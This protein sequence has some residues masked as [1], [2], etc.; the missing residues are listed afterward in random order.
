MP[1]PRSGRSVGCY[2]PRVNLGAL[3][4]RSGTLAKALGALS[5]LVALAA[6]AL[7]S[8]VGASP[9]EDYHL[10]SVW[11]GHGTRDGACEEGP[12]SAS[13]RVPAA[14]Y[15]IACFAFE[16]QTSASCQ[17]DVLAS[18]ERLMVI[19]RG[20]FTGDYPPVFYFFMSLFA[21]RDIVVSAAVMRLVNAVLFVA[22]IAATYIASPPRLRRP[23]LGGIAVTVVPLSMF[24]VPSINPSSWA[25]LSAATLLVSVLGY[26]TTDE[27]GRR[28]VLGG[29]AALSLLFGAGARADAAV[30]AVVAIAAALV[31]T[32][33]SGTRHIRRA[34]YPVVLAIIAGVSFLSSGQS[35]AI[36]GGQSQGLTLARV[37]HLL[38]DVPSLWAGCLGTWG[39]GWVDTPM[40]A[41]VWVATIGIFAGVVFVAI[42]GMD[43][44]RALALGLVGAAVWLVPAYLQ[45]L[46]GVPVGFD[47]QP[48]YILPLLIVLAVT[49]LVRLDGAVFRLTQGQRWIFVLALSVANAVALHTNLRRYI[50]GIDVESL[51]LNAHKEWWWGLPISPLGVWALGALA[52]A[53]GL[54]ILSRELT[55]VVAVPAEVAAA[56]EEPEP[57]TDDAP[58]AEP[59]GVV[60]A[61]AETATPHEEPE[62]ET[63]AAG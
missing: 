19:A 15:N 28:L 22:M 59:A 24:I 56:D 4:G 34:I 2:A 57:E 29:L 27:R 31:L 12:D 58:S 50:T 37:V 13:R 35:G 39:L 51:N 25:V 33:R 21:G 43:R 3:R 60:A 54:A 53:V 46:S 48:R 11:C 63:D 55:G 52:F 7:A 9:D 44:R 30:Y 62:P 23:L 38:I 16:P 40:P 1:P 26:M 10:A 18:S 6:W 42:A 17:G 45:Y 5:I 20:N 8:P 36:E 32:V 14:F 49:A 41:L 61:R 47:V